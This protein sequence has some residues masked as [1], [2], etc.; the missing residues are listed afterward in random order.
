[1]ENNYLEIYKLSIVLSLVIMVLTVTLIM[2]I[3]YMETK[4]KNKL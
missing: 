4:S 2:F 1:M 3:N